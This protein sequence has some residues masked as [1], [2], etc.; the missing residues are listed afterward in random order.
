MMAWVRIK[1]KCAAA[2]QHLVPGQVLAVPDEMPVSIANVLARMG[3]AE[4]L[5]EAP[6]DK[7]ARSRKAKAEPEAAAE[8]TAA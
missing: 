3:R 5:D 6:S 1:Q 2:G 7:P 4:V 8:E